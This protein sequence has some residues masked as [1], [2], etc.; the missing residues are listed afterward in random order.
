MPVA[1]RLAILLITPRAALA[2]ALSGMAPVGRQIAAIRPGSDE[3][4]LN[5]MDPRGARHRAGDPNPY[6]GVSAEV[7][8]MS[9]MQG[10]CGPPRPAALHPPTREARSEP[11]RTAP[12]PPQ[13][14]VAAI[15]YT[16][17]IIL[18]GDRRAD[19]AKPGDEWSWVL[20]QRPECEY[21]V[22][23][24]HPPCIATRVRSAALHRTARLR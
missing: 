8:H 22:V 6:S 16:K 2:L 21:R 3:A 4:M 18:N 9:W 5:A 24:R 20:G 19:T 11:T 17:W 10:R 7:P 23:D 1:R 13:R 15:G 14:E 12:I